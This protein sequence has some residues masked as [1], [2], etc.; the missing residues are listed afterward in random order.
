MSAAPTPEW[1]LLQTVKDYLATATPEQVE[2]DMR[3]SG[4]YD[5]AI[6]P[7]TIDPDEL[8]RL[9]SHPISPITTRN[10]P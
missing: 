2:K 3:D 7:S 5:F 8:R 1:D 4:F 9:T 10:L 6:D